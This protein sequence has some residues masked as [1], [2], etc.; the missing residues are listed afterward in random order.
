MAPKIWGGGGGGGG[1]GEFDHFVY[2]SEST[3][4]ACSM[5]KKKIN[6]SKLI[7]STVD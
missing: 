7:P 5:L 4:S 2:E 1:G 6:S 3:L